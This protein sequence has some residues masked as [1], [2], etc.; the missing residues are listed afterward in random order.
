MRR[1]TQIFQ[2]FVFAVF[3]GMMSVPSGMAQQSDET[4]VDY[5]LWDTTAERAEDAIAAGRASDVALEN[6]RGQIAAWRDGFATAQGQ[7]TP[8]IA[9]LRAQI[10]ALGPLPT[11]GTEAEEIA[12]RRQQ[13]T[14]ELSDARAPVQKAE[15][16]WTQADGLISQIDQIIRD[17]SKDQILSLGPTPLN[18]ANW[19][20][21]VG[22]LIEGTKHIGD[23]FRTAWASPIQ[24][25]ETKSN[26]LAIAVLTLIGFILM[27]RGRR[28]SERL[29][30]WLQMHNQVAW[31][32]LL[33]FAVS[34]GQFVLPTLGV[35]ALTFA[36]YATGLVGLGGDVLLQ[37]LP[38]AGFVF[39]MASWLGA[40][41][42]PRKSGDLKYLNLSAQQ[43]TEGRFYSASLGAMMALNG[44]V[45]EL[46]QFLNLPP[47]IHV[48]LVFPILV[49]VALMVARIGQL[50]SAHYRNETVDDG[51]T[52]PN[53]RCRMLRLL[54]RAAVFVALGGATLAAIGY[55]SAGQRLVFP[56]ASTLGLLA[57]VLI[58]QRL[59]SEIWVLVSGRGEEARDT[60]VPVLAGFALTVAALP[61]LALSWGMR[62]ATL[63]EY[64]AKFLQ[65]VPLGD[66]RISPTVFITLAV[67]FSIGYMVTKLVQGA[68]RNTIL[69]KTKIDPGGQNAIV[70]GMGYVGIFLAALIA[71]TGAGI[72]LSALAI[73][74]G[75]LSVG[76]GFG[77]QNIVSNF[78]SG[79]ILLIER[80]IAEGDWIEVSGQSGT[81]KSISVR[82]TRI[83]TFDRAD[84]IVPNADL[85]SGVVMNMTKGNLTGR[86]IV[87]VGVAYGSDTR[88]IE[89]ILQEIAEAHPLVVMNPGPGVVFKGFGADSMDFEIRAVL[90]DINF[91]LG[92]RSE[93]NH[94]I[95]ERFA[96]E[97]IEI[98]FAQRDIWLRNPEALSGNTTRATS[99]VPPVSPKKTAA[100]D[101][102]RDFI[103]SQ[104]AGDAGDGR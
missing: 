78:V 72:D 27:L 58:L 54:G 103:D 91:G 75:A 26:G 24:Q 74:A 43:R 33:G 63:S 39:F 9:S 18:P 41:V 64:W 46:S 37:I 60:L 88:K 42:F 4:S 93:M 66:T 38:A 99:A 94:Q 67:I 21:A 6:L 84:V 14:T 30:L 49:L 31:R 59:F 45:V 86:I 70:S 36:V 55:F 81:V 69:P 97:G 90:R 22:A 2:I 35:L 82:S 8:Q 51:E 83:E 34:L 50:L 96:A 19:G 12:Q 89:A 44:I 17:R 68:L 47:E 65:G 28:W 71:I 87:P 5:T 29:S 10:A 16:A 102:D 32:W 23:E 3:L 80:P 100:D 11:E 48:V 13:L 25:A 85:I 77:L 57:F 1:F 101:I 40:R 61:L 52:P 20:P 76:I 92:V 104:D 15:A 98:P 95:A 7:N 73:V 56:A 53:Y 79:I 62:A